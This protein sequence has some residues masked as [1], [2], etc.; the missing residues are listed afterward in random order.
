MNKQIVMLLTLTMILST[1][2]YPT[3]DLLE[4][5]GTTMET[6]AR[7]SWAD[8]EFLHEFP[9]ACGWDDDDTELCDSFGVD[10]GVLK[11]VRSTAVFRRL[12]QNCRSQIKIS[13]GI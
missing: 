2:P 7:D 3:E 1:L 8:G 9:E 12:S 4:V 5:E 13:S 6:S 11:V 10:F